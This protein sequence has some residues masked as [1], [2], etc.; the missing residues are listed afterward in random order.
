MRRKKQ[1]R[2]EA[3]GWAVGSAGAFLGLSHDEDAYLQLRQRLTE[4]LRRRR[5]A[6]GLSQ[7]EFAARLRT[8]Q[9]RL[10]KMEAGD[11]SVSLD[12]LIRSLLA[13]GVSTR[14]LARAIAG[15]SVAASE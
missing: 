11:T 2:L 9:S 13:L 5:Q 12:L 14:A 3:R 1:E 10:A 4:T 8:S 6:R 15:R 7:T